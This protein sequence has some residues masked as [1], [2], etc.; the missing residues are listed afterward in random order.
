MQRIVLY[1]DDL[2]RCPSDRVVELLEAVHLLLA[3][4]LFVVVVGVGETR[5]FH[6]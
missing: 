4:A 2:D 5:R 1:V 3:F 6:S